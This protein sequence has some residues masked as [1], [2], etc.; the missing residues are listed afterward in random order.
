M[1]RAEAAS[2]VEFI[3]HYIRY[4]SDCLARG[5]P[6]TLAKIAGV[7]RIGYKNTQTGQAMRQD[8]LVME[9]LFYARKVSRIFDLKV[10]TITLADAV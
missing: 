4:A 6:T 2:V 1:S 3:P 10:L 9:N 7:F 5:V 8:V